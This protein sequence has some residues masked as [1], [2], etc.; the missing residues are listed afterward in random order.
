MYKHDFIC[1]PAQMISEQDKMVRMQIGQLNLYF[2]DRGVNIRDPTVRF[3]CPG[4]LSQE[5]Q[6]TSERGVRNKW[7]PQCH[8]RYHNGVHMES[9]FQTVIRESNKRWKTCKHMRVIL[10]I[11]VRLHLQQNGWLN[12]EFYDLQTNFSELLF[13]LLY[14]SPLPFLFV[15]NFWPTITKLHF[16]FIIEG[17]FANY[18]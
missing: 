13:L 6:V 18:L 7:I 17:L 11:C 5:K 12:P 8:I 15:L 3:E 16:L 10:Q 2:F 9:R 1:T 14:K 4:R